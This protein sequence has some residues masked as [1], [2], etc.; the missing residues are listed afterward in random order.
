MTPFILYCVDELAVWSLA[1]HYTFGTIAFKAGNLSSSSALA[2]VFCSIPSCLFWA[3][4]PLPVRTEEWTSWAHVCLE[5]QVTIE[6]SSRIPG[7]NWCR[8]GVG[9]QG[10]QLLDR[11]FKLAHRNITHGWTVR[12]PYHAATLA[13]N[14]CSNT[15]EHEAGQ[16]S[17]IR[18]NIV[19]STH[20]Q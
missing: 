9:K 1:P 5:T 11:T 14:V 3:Y 6:C 20:C 10:W 16:K 17:T 12:C 18:Q 13:H 2:I 7:E 19:R 8:I 15:C 4:S